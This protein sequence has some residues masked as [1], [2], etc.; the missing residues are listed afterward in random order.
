MSVNVRAGDV[1]QLMMMPPSVREWLPEDHLAFFVLDVVSELDLSVFYAAHRVDGRGGSVY[2]PAMMLAVLL[3]AYCTAERSSRR[4]ERRLV[5]DVAVRV[6]AANQ[7]P[8]HATLARFRRRHQGAIAALFGQVLGLCV[9]AGLV[10]A[11]VVAIDGTKI[12]AN[13]SFF[14]NRDHADLSA[15]LAGSVEHDPAAAAARRVA[16]RV[17][18][19]AEEVDAAEDDDG[20]NDQLRRMPAG[21]SGGRDRRSRIRAALDEIESQKSRDFEARMAERARKEDELGRKLTGPKPSTQTARRV[22]PRRAN[23]TDPDSRIIPQASKG[24]V[25]GYNAQAAATT[26]HIVVAAEIS[27]TTNDQ[28]HFVPMATAVNT[29][30]TDA[31]HRG[32]TGTC[33]A[34]AGYWTSVNGTTDVGAEV[35][36]ATRKSAWRKAD[37]PDDDKLAVL[38]RVNRGELSQ[39]QA[40]AILGVSYTWVRDMTKRYFGHDGQRITRS[41]E[42]EPDEWIPVVER[43]AAGEISLRAASDHL[44][45]SVS[46]VKTMLAHVRGEIIDP[47]IARNTMNDKLSQ[48]ENDALYRKRAVS[49]EPVFGNIKANLGF[50][51]F[52]LRGHAGVHSEW[53]LICTVHN[54]LKLQRAISA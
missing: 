22:R 5:E 13:A 54:L 21:W 31:G 51:K 50:R 42:P 16:D 24:V 3:Y 49:I 10:D 35:L 14:A 41:A 1:D 17:L 11:G 44:S 15:E 38:A 9:T 8:D 26:G 52:S 4:I 25:Q 48:P 7:Q 39:R 33:V 18:A 53:R 45:V 47:T 2:D 30:L 46:R 20:E 37:K 19:E 36:I 43:V 27:N 29:N 12:S 32:G 28:P 6:V 40:G 34:D 23:T